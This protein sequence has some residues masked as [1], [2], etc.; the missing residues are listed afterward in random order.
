MTHHITPMITRGAALL[1]FDCDDPAC[2]YR[3][4]DTSTS[5]TWPIRNACAAALALNRAD[6]LDTY[7]GAPGAVIAAAPIEVRLESP[8]AMAT[9]RYGG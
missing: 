7:D 1:V 8:G 2:D 6:W 9:W 4:P 5:G 3:G